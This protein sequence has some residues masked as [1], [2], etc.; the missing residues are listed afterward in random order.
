MTKWPALLCSC[1]ALV[2]VG[3]G[4]DDEEEKGGGEAKP[5]K[6]QP[7][8]GGGGGKTV[9]VSMKDTQFK[10]K[11]LTVAKGTTVRWVNDDSV[12]H[13][14]TKTGGPGPSFKSGAP[15]GLSKG[16]TYQEK[17]TTAGKV[18]YICTV[19]QPSMSGTITV[20]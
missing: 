16:D 10:P 15:G 9:T 20:K 19:H 11:D 18:T 12:G 5:Q 17:L 2:V 3:C 6:Q 14:V 7:A 13:D 1:L 8:G 4:G